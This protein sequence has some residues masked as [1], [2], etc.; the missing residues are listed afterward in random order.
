MN[1]VA[2]LLVFLGG[3][4]C[5]MARVRGVY[6]VRAALASPCRQVLCTNRTRAERTYGHPDPHA[7]QFLGHLAFLP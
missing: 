4:A 3:S 6:P 5:Q 1:E 7:D 2:A